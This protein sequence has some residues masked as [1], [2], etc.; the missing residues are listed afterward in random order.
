MVLVWR[1]C[2]TPQKRYPCDRIIFRECKN[3]F[4]GFLLLISDLMLAIF[5]QTSSVTK[6]TIMDRMNKVVGIAYT[7]HQCSY[8]DRKI[9]YWEKSPNNDNMWV[10][11]VIWGILMHVQ[12]LN[13]F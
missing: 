9:P 10:G 6:R 12:F 2:Y 7:P 3:T 13:N 8:S 11:V 1:V 4:W 5:T